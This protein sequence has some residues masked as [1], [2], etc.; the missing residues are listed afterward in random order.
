MK[1]TIKTDGGTL[2][3]TLVQTVRR[4]IL[5]QA[6]EGGLT[7]VYAPKSA[8]LREIDAIV[9]ENAAKIAA[10]N[11]A[12]KPAPLKN[13]GTVRIEGAPRTVVI[14]K[15]APDVR[16]TDGEFIISAP[17]PENA[18]AVRAQ[19]LAFLSAMA[20]TRIRSRLEYYRPLTG[21]D[22]NRV[23]VRA[24]RSRWGSCSSKRNLNFNWKLI[25]AP[26]MCLDYVVLHELCHLTEFN[27][28]RRF[29]QLVETHMRD[30][31][32]W[33]DWLRINGKALT[34]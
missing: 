29:W 7:K 24:Q 27:H 5:I 13:G 19:A 8:R 26:P 32:V 16:L 12:L 1:R 4:D 9:R 2:E 33:K 6:L 14:S 3:Y 20:L 15:G 21:G 31:R 25:L 28:S 10:M 23:T 11:E 17:E 22:Y 18:D 30:Y 34:I